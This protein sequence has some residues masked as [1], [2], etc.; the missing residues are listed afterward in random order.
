MISVIVPAFNAAST[1][2]ETVSSALNQTY[3]NLEVIIVDDGSTDQTGRVA[4]QLV[5]RDPRVRY[6]H[7]DNGGVASAR[8]RGIVEAQGEF[9]ATLDADDLWYPMKLERQLQ[10][11]EQSGSETAL[12]YAWCCW[13]DDDG[14]VTGSAPPTQ[15]EGNILPEMCLGNVIISGSNALIRREALIAAGGFDESLRAKSAQGCEDLKLYLTIAERHRIAMVPEYLVGYRVSPGSMSDD[16]EQMMRSRHLVEAEFIASHPELAL[17]FARGRAILAR[18]LALRAIDRGQIRE[19][20]ELLTNQSQGRVAAGFA[21]LS[22]LMGGAIRRGL[23]WLKTSGH[24]PFSEF[25][26]P[27][28]REPGQVRCVRQEKNQGS[29]CDE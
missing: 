4:A 5:Q 13:I 2:D 29:H 26:P 15:L 22:W 8:N 23:R 3:C 14:T 27:P 21:S 16:F 24:R 12:V 20:I 10:R 6:V 7:K 17:Q 18:S 1:I 28:R 11:F 25:L 19:A 9:V